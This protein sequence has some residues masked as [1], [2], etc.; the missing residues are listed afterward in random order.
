MDCF[1]HQ[2]IKPKSKALDTFYLENEYPGK[3]GINHGP[4]FY[5]TYREYR[6]F[7]WIARHQAPG[8]QVIQLKPI[9]NK[10]TIGVPALV[11]RGRQA[12]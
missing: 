5:L 9:N 1:I 10:M 3:Y 4:P 7:K 2:G 8:L 6:A 11:F 12:E